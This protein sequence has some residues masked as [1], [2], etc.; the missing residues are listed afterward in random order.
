MNCVEQFFQIRLTVNAL[1]SHLTENKMKLTV[2][3]L[4]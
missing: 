2:K 1:D 3:L 4:S